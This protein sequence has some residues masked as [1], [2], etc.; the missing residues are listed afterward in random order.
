MYLVFP[1]LS[2]VVVI[3]SWV[4]FVVVFCMMADPALAFLTILRPS[5]PSRLS[6]TE[7]SIGSPRGDSSPS[8]SLLRSPIESPRE[9]PTLPPPSSPVEIPPLI[10]YDAESVTLTRNIKARLDA[11]CDDEDSSVRSRSPSPVSLPVDKW[12]AFL[13]GLMGKPI[14]DC[15]D[16]ST[17][18]VKSGILQNRRARVQESRSPSPS[19]DPALSR[20]ATSALNS[21]TRFGSNSTSTGH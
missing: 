17:Y 4:I 14:R 21:S 10:V 9:D 3:L 16:S 18:V 6:V 5:P 8:P 12:R 7:S 11:L 2:S 20:A 13:T 1:N 15:P 19:R